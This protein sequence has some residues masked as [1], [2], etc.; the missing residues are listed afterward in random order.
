MRN[1]CKLWYISHTSEHSWC[2]C[3]FGGVLG[4]GLCLNQLIR[5]LP[6]VAKYLQLSDATDFINEIKN[7]LELYISRGIKGIEYDS[8]DYG[9]FDYFKSTPGSPYEFTGLASNAYALKTGTLQ[10]LIDELLDVLWLG[11]Y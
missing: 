6:V 5:N 2:G 1:G 10:N 3:C 4:L 7:L 9:L 8:L 11:K